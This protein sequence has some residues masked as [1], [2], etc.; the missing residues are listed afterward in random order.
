MTLS[1]RAQQL[2]E[3]DAC[4]GNLERCVTLTDTLYEMCFNVKPS[5]ACPFTSFEVDWD[6]GQKQSYPTA[7][8]VEIRHKYDLR[9]FLKNCG[10]GT[11]KQFKIFITTNCL[12]N[13]KGAI[14]TFKIKPSA[15]FLVE[16]CEGRPATIQNR[17]CPNTNDMTWLWDFGDGTTSALANPSKTFPATTTSYKVKLT[18]T[19]SCGTSTHE[20]TVPVKKIPVAKYNASGYVVNPVNVTDTV[21]CLSNGGT[22]AM[23]ATISLDATSYSWQISPS[24]YRFINGTNASSPKPQIQFNRSGTYTVTLIARN[25]CGVSQ[26]M[27]C[28][29]K[30]VDLPSPRLLPQ[31]DTCQAFN[32]VVASPIAGATY[33]LNGTAFLPTQSQLVSPSTTPY[34]VAVNLSNTCGNQTVR[35]TFLV[36]P[37]VPVHITNPVGSTVLCTNASPLLLTADLAGGTWT[38]TNQAEITQQGGRS[39]FNPRTPGRV[40][41]TYQRGTGVC[42]V[43]DTVLIEVQGIQ[44][45]AQSVSVCSGQTTV[46]LE[47][48]P[49]GGRW[50]TT[51][52]VNCLTGNL[53]TLTGI[54]AA[55]IRVNY[56]LTT[57]G[58]C[59]ASAVATVTIGQPQTRFTLAN[60]CSG[61]PIKAVN[62]SIGATTFQWLVNGNPVSTE[63][64]PALQLP[65]GSVRV[66]LISMAGSCSSTVSQ[67]VT[68]T[69][70]PALISFTPSVTH[71]C[72][73]L[74]VSFLMNGIAQPGVNYQWDFGNQT[75][76]TSFQ[77]DPQSFE[78]NG[79]QPQSFIITLSGSN[80]CGSL[81]KTTQI[82]TVLP[83]AKAQIGVDSTTIRCPPTNVTFTNRSTGF[84][85]NVTWDFGDRTPPISSTAPVVSHEYQSPAMKQIYTVR[86]TVNSD[87]GSDIDS[88]QITVFPKE[89]IPSFTIS[90][91]PICVGDKITFMDASTP[92]P[93]LVK[94]EIDGHLLEGKTVSYNQFTKPETRYT[95]KMTVYPVCGGFATREQTIITGPIPTG[96]FKVPNVNCVSQPVSITNTSDARLSFKWNFG[97]GSPT[98]SM[99]YSPTHTY[100]GNRDTYI[101][102]MTIT[103]FPTACTAVVSHPI[104]LRQGSQPA[105]RIAN[106]GVIC[107]DTIVTM[108]DQSQN[109][110]AWKWYANGQ[111]ISTAKNPQIKLNRGHYDIKLWASNGACADSLTQQDAVLVDT[112]TLYV[113]SVFTPDGNNISD[114]FNIYGS[115]LTKIHEMRIF[116][117]WGVRVY[118][119]TNL[120]PNSQT[121]GWDGQHNG[122]PL[123]ADNYVYETIVEFVGGSV[124]KRR[125]VLTLL[126]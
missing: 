76:S 5:P 80:S 117:R 74:P 81:P 8:P 83:K 65:T 100:A 105:F 49:A 96:D 119:A 114:R 9:T 75:S 15:N 116:N 13:N 10:S 19:N 63:R 78:N 6:D 18:A 23:D 110:T 4:T 42:A 36:A 41:I 64:E 26:P 45:I 123:P 66:T 104:A 71:G 14:L 85:G 122:Q 43:K 29:H 11:T 61:T 93:A 16:A 33:T 108:E 97:D 82:I 52:C 55:S 118:E 39:F 102:A 46:A 2:V 79:R 24:T 115:N 99:F 62:N 67:D 34:I 113:A 101:I 124:K 111:L 98:D 90:K 31:P 68:I 35:D 28:T 53:L 40:R 22:L 20:E 27:V 3:F 87:C 54:T 32:Y 89:V 126:R 94:W 37:S 107:S 112:C 30:V 57:S 91:N 1:V 38:G 17:S 51:D 47:G 58:G 7:A 88:T 50:T 48:S 92:V 12:G 125:G 86:L 69:A 44:V 72:S 59:S 77:P 84:N 109:A 73:P 25:S 60:G 103:G 56:V 106:N 120:T 95:I 121:E 21:V 70:P